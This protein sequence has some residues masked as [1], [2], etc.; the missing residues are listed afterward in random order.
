MMLP[1][2]IKPVVQYFSVSLS[3]QRKEVR[4]LIC[5]DVAARGIDIH[6]VPYGNR[7]ILDFQY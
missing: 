6:G 3:S 5:T 2:K 4:I 7:K 1:D